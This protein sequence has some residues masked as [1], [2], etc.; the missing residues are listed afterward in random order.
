MP[1]HNEKQRSVRYGKRRNREAIIFSA[2]PRYILPLTESSF[3]VPPTIPPGETTRRS[4]KTPVQIK[5]PQVFI[6]EGFQR[7]L[8]VENTSLVCS[9]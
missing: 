3:C 5:I 4:V 7:A 8:L 9:R 2:F 6:D 1:N